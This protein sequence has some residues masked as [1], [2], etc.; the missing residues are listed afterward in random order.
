LSD[1]DL[2]R[3]ARAYVPLTSSTPV[4]GTADVLDEALVPE[5]TYD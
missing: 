3:V 4:P 5:L 2:G 1:R